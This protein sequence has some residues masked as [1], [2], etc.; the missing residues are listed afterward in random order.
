MKNK[1]NRACCHY[2]GNHI[3]PIYFKSF[4][5][6]TSM[7]VHIRAGSHRSHPC[8]FTTALVHI[9]PLFIKGGY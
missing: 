5:R 3:K 9:A 8:G 2:L 4:A 1:Y 7:L 6:F